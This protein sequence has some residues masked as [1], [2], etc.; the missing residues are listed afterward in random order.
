MNPFFYGTHFKQIVNKKRWIVKFFPWAS[1]LV[2]RRV[3]IVVKK[4]MIRLRDGEE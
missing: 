2:K 3:K 1:E 4:W